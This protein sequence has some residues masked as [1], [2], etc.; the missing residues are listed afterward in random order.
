MSGLVGLKKPFKVYTNME[1]FRIWNQ[2]W[3]S[4]EAYLNFPKLLAPWAKLDRY[5]YYLCT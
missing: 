2:I 4:L 5:Y 3:S 1:V